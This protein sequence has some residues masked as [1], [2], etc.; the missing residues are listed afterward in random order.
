MNNQ[1]EFEERSEDASEFREGEVLKWYFRPWT[2]VAAII[3]FGPLGLIPLWYRPKT[4]VHV[5]VLVSVAVI[6]LTYWM[7]Q[8]TFDVYKSMMDYYRILGDLM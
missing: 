3:C 6:A 7:M 8:F 5:K 1:K 4:K 2:I